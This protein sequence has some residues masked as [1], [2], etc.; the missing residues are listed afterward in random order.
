MIG[1]IVNY[2]YEVLE[3]VGD[4]ELFSVYKSRDKVLN[5]LVALKVLNKDVA[6]CGGFASAVSEGYRAVTGLDHPNIAR[7]FEAD[8]ADGE[9]FVACEYVRGTNVK[10]RVR[11]AGPA[12]VAL[13]LDIA[14]PVLEALEYAHANGIVHGN[15]R[16]QDIIVSPDGEVKLTDFG[17]SHALGKCPE[18]ADRFAMRSVHYAAPEIAEGAPP[19]ASSDLYSVGVV[20]YEMLTG[21][22]P[23]AGATAVAVAL[24]QAKEL[25][26]PPRAINTGVPKSLSDF[27]M[28]AIEKSPVDRFHSASE[29]LA[30][31]RTMRDALR[32]GKPLSIPQ[33]SVTV[34]HEPPAAMGEAG[35][36]SL[37]RPYL[38][39]VLIFVVV[40]L[41]SMG[42]VMLFQG[43]RGKVELPVLVDKSFSEAKYEAEKAGLTL[44]RGEEVFSDSIEEGNVCGIYQETETKGGRHIL[45]LQ[46]GDS[47]ER[48][49]V[50]SARISKGPSWKSVPDL[51]GLPESDAYRA[52]EDEGFRVGKSTG[53]YDEKVP[54]NSVIRQT[55]SAGAKRA[56]G[57]SITIVVSMG[58]KP[59]TDTESDSGTA[60]LGE[61]RRFNVAVEVPSDSDDSQEVRIVVEDSRGE[62]VAYQRY[63]DPGDKFTQPV[64]TYGSNARIM[65][66]VGGELVSDD[67]Y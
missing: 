2:R 15:I 52:A 21:V 45:T 22:L 39:L 48:N 44:V 50:I 14:I 18:V 17:L 56:P 30:D 25:P 28:R 19:S 36:P 47:V 3:K 40:V 34:P 43:E 64:T 58:P 66:Y 26:T 10:E 33:P 27:I 4:G 51:T 67:N 41:A 38:W 32:I 7:V 20:L 8:S 13:A 55:P 59:V 1:H 61:A 60:N 29:M 31:L 9:H 35:E 42:A 11:R 62:T 16:P 6:S 37:M 12:S 5:R 23:F 65:V 24:K 49:S 46:P 53:E 63:H 54:A 57:S